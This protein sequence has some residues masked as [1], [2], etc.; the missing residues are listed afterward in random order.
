MNTQTER[1]ITPDVVPAVTPNLSDMGGGTLEEMF[2]HVQMQVFEN[3][4]DENTDAGFKRKVIIEIVYITD[5]NRDDV[6]V[7]FQ[8]IPKLAPIKHGKAHMFVRAT[9]RGIECRQLLKPPTTLADY[10]YED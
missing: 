4:L 3:I 7:G 6:A 1:S 2:Q 9:E 10:G 5:E 8:V